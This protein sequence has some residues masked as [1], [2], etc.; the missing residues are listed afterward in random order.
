MAAAVAFVT[1]VVLVWTD[2][3]LHLMRRTPGLGLDT[4]FDARRRQDLS[5]WARLEGIDPE[6]IP[7]WAGSVRYRFGWARVEVMVQDEHGRKMLDGDD[8][9]T[10]VIWKRVT[11][12]PPHLEGDRRG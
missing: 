2:P 6:R 7:V 5:E 12:R 1:A 3:D 8:L 4:R 11:S 10:A 9:K